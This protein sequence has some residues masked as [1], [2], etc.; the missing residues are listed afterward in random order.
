MSGVSVFR[1]SSTDPRLEIASIS[2]DVANGFPELLGFATPSID[3][4]ISGPVIE[5]KL[6]CR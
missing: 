3:Q 1:R 2:G 5:N 4:L 6:W